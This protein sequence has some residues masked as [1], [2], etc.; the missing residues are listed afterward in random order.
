MYKRGH[1]GPWQDG[2]RSTNGY[3][4]KHYMKQ[5]LVKIR[6]P[7]QEL[8]RNLLLGLTI[9]KLAGLMSGLRREFDIRVKTAKLYWIVLYISTPSSRKKVSPLMLYATLYSTVVFEIS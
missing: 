4:L 9:Q 2:A 5:S 1:L 3:L 8:W 7:A 6:A